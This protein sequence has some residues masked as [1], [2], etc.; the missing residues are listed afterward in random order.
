MY[1]YYFFAF[2]CFAFLPQILETDMQKMHTS[3]KMNTKSFLNVFS[4]FTD[5]KKYISF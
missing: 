5:H 4:L 3:F 2:D 1:M